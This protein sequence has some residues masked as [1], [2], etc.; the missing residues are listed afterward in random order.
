MPLPAGRRLG[1]YEVLG[2]LGAGGMGEVYR[3]RDPRLRREVAIKVLPAEVSG[4]PGRRARFEREAHAVASLSHPNILA[5]H[6]VG[7]DGGVIYAVMELLEGRTLREVVRGGPMRPAEAVDVA[8]QIARG[9][10]AAH[11]RGLVHRDVKPENVVVLPDGHVK[12]LDFGLVA[13]RLDDVPTGAPT[14]TLELATRP[15]VLLGTPGYMAPEQVRGEAADHRSDVFALGCV[16]YEMLSGTR[17]FKGE[18]AVDTLH[19]TLRLE[20]PTLSS[21]GGVPADLARVVSRCLEKARKDRFQSAREVAAALD[22]VGGPDRGRPRWPRV[23]AP[24]A[25]LAVLALGWAAW[26]RAPAGLPAAP[27]APDARGIAVLPFETI[28]PPDQ[29]YFATGLTEEVTLQLAKV[30]SL[31]V[32]S[33]AAVTRFG[34]GAA[35]LPAMA[36]ELRIGAVLTGSVRHAG[37]AVRVGVQLVAAPGGETLWSGEYDGD[38]G[39][40]L[41]AQSDVAVRVARSLQASLAPE[42]RARIERPPTT[43]PA[44]YDLFL[45]ARG[46]SGRNLA[47]IREAA[48]LLERAVALDPR[49]ALAHAQLARWYLFRGYHTGRED[50]V[51][52]V[53]AG[54]T[55]VGLD[56]QLA[57][58]HYALAGALAAS[59]DIEGSRL[60][61]LRAIELDSS[62]GGAMN[63]LSVTEWLAGRF[64]QSF[65]WAMRAFPLAPNLANSCYHVGVPLLVL[66]DEAAGRWLLAAERRFPAADATGGQRLQILL[67]ALDLGRGRATAALERMRAA[68]A[69]EPGSDEGQLTLTEMA[70]FAG[71]K[72]APAQVDRA[73]AVGP[74][75][76]G[77]WVLLSTP[78]TWRAHLW[79]QAGVPARAQPLVD[80]ALAAN[81]RASEGG[82]RSFGLLY[83]NAALALMRGE[84]KAALD[85][86]DRAY[87]AGLRDAASLQHDPMLASVWTDGRFVALLERMRKD[88]REMRARV[89]LGELD[90]WMGTDARP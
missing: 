1:V 60:G 8:R 83:E 90:R 5:I 46:R 62:L 20:P 29:A 23:A 50:L 73:L 53:E 74:E 61:M 24:L 77:S 4:D 31:R 81:R 52:A 27:A 39:N 64:D 63:D 30:R 19:A 78:R 82:D 85:W 72:D 86:L 22:V 7:E 12:V 66:D 56:P 41:A 9:L 69:A 10:E 18:S 47:E 54:R 2:P 16:L 26:R 42:E 45:K 51:R 11:S 80:A 79:L 55:A 76:R 43:V 58:A 35:E 32:I 36:R 37:E 59:G 88:V 13:A 49:F 21:L 17:A 14:E 25:V 28:G 65:Y 33:R 3:A 89:D 67:A 68:V 75:A 84:R 57:R 44:A 70:V 38:L 15:G 48:S 87:A 40:I 71:A 6:D 34:R